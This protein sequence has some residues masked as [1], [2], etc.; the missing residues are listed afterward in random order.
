[1]S[2]P[3]P[4]LSLPAKKKGKK[5]RKTGSAAATPAA[6]EADTAGNDAMPSLGLPSKRKKRRKK[7]PSADSEAADGADN[8]ADDGAAGGDKDQG[9]FVAATGEEYEYGTLLSR[10]FAT[11]RKLNPN[12]ESGNKQLQLEA[13]VLMR[14]GTKKTGF[15]NMLSIC[16]SINRSPQHVLSFMLAELGTTGTFSGNG[17][18]TIKGRFQVKHIE[19]VLRRYITTYVLCFNC[20]SSNTQLAK[21]QR[22]TMIECGSCQSRRAVSTISSGFQAQVGRRRKR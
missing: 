5:K 18:L 6:D 22:L 19:N 13:P 21:E 1:M 11:M 4:E 15:V 8:G 2:E 17:R 14:V 16:E 7:K 20:K 3:V 12:I 10:A 9:T